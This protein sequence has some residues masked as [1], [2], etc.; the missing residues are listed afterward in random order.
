MRLRDLAG[1]LGAVSSLLHKQ[2]CKEIQP[3]W[4]MY[5]FIL[6]FPSPLKWQRHTA[7]QER[8]SSQTKAPPV[9]CPPRRPWDSMSSGTAGASARRHDN[10]AIAHLAATP[11]TCCL[12]LG[13][14]PPS[15]AISC[16]CN[17]KSL[18][19]PLSCCT[20]LRCRSSCVCRQGHR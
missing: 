18:P 12:C 7:L 5:P 9:G 16:P 20:E 3:I 4:M 1:F 11:H 13:R 19:W 6:S 15:G 8:R 14:S 10:P 17:T 2:F